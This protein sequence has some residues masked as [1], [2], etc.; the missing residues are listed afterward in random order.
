MN[1]Q[2]HGNLMFVGLLAMGVVIW[3]LLTFIL[4]NFVPSISHQLLQPICV[5]IAVL[6]TL[7]VSMRYF[8]RKLISSKKNPED[9]GH[10]QT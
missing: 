4:G 8:N 7:G 9:L 6:I 1:D 2:K 3:A 5:S 10:P